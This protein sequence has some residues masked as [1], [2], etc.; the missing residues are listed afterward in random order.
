MNLNFIFFIYLLFIALL[1]NSSQQNTQR[2]V[3]WCGDCDEL[4]I[5]RKEEIVAYYKLLP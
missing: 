5:I 1:N 2:T 3:V 4:E